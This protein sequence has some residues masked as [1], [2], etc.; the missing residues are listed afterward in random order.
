MAYY[1]NP[2]T[3]AAPQYDNSPEGMARRAVQYAKKDF[4]LFEKVL[5]LVCP[6]VDLTE[7][8]NTICKIKHADVVAAVERRSSIDTNYD[9]AVKSLLA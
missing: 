3:A 4:P 6:D 8:F 1:N 9:D 5:P 7:V 2:Q